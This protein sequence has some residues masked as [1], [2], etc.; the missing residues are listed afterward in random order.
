M[1]RGTFVLFIFTLARLTAVDVRDTTAACTRR[2]RKHVSAINNN[3]M[4]YMVLYYYYYR[5]R[6]MFNF[7]SKIETRL[8]V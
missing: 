3:I 1:P 4:S 2:I 8:L 7:V 5:N 6:A